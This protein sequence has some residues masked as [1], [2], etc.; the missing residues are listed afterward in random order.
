MVN[1]LHPLFHSLEK[2]VGMNNCS[3]LF[4]STES[5]W[6]QQTKDFF[7]FSVAHQ[8]LLRCLLYSVLIWLFEKHLDHILMYRKIFKLYDYFLWAIFLL[9]VY[10]NIKKLLN[11]SIWKSQ[12]MEN[13]ICHLWYLKIKII[14]STYFSGFKILGR[15]RTTW[16]I[17][18]FW[19]TPSEPPC[20]DGLH[21]IIESTFRFLHILCCNSL[22]NITDV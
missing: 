17:G 13:S 7:F 16:Y 4:H 6:Q 9:T 5:C 15:Y 12:L 19:H 10:S 11:L 8:K 22:R 20:L 3:L 18:T 14:Q 2:N 1:Y 21:K